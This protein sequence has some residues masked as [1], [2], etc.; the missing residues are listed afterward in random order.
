MID[1]T[2]FTNQ[3]MHEK[4][5]RR[6]GPWLAFGIFLFP[7]FFVWPLVRDGHTLRSRVIGFGWLFFWVFVGLFGDPGDV[8][9]SVG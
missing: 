3:L 4:P 8:D 6:V 7:L 1:W 5:V 2:A 9:I